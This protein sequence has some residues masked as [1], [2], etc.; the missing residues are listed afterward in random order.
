M[1]VEG[2]AGKKGQ[3]GSVFFENYKF[4]GQNLYNS[5]ERKICGRA[6]CTFLSET[7]SL[8]AGIFQLGV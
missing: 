3:F 7:M 6:G 8:V 5:D 2:T 1:M 4:H